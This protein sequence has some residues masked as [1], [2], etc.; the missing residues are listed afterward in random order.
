MKIWG[1]TT[2]LNKQLMVALTPTEWSN[3]QYACGIPYDRHS[4]ETGTDVDVK[5]I[6]ESVNAYTQLKEMRKSMI[7]LSKKWEK[8]ITAMDAILGAKQ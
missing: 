6:Q 1:S 3:L 2:G 5:V 4:Q 8:T 7:E